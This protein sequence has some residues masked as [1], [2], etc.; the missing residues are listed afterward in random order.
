MNLPIWKPVEPLG[1]LFLSPWSQATQV[2][3]G[4]PLHLQTGSSMQTGT[5]LVHLCPEVWLKEGHP[6]GTHMS[7]EGKWRGGGKKQLQGNKAALGPGAKESNAHARR[8]G[9]MLEAAGA[10]GENHPGPEGVR[11]T[12]QGGKGE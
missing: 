11:E 5:S 1:G 9:P 4:L 8:T 6:A 10:R 12:S 7:V 2:P 3:S